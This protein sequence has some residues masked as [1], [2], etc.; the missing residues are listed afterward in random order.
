MLYL[1]TE[2]TISSLVTEPTHSIIHQS[3]NSKEGEEPLNGD[4]FGLAWYAPHLPEEPALFKAVTPAWNNM[5]LLSLARVTKSSCIL[6]HVR[7]ATPGLPVIQLNCHPF[8]RGSISFMHNGKVGGFA[9]IRR[10]IIERL[11][12]AAFESIEGSTDSEYVFALFLDQY[13][14]QDQGLAKSERLARALGATIKEVNSIVDEAGIEDASFLN[15]AVAD[16]TSAVVCRY[17]SCGSKRANT[18][19][20]HTGSS[21]SCVDG[22]YTMAEPDKG[23]HAVVVASEPLGSNSEW[24][25]V[26]ESSMVV[27]ESG[28]GVVM[29]PIQAPPA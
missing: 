12:D 3:Y 7:A 5:N 10:R 9:K 20:I 21:F 29:R 15:L 11:S 6:A 16:G 27:I 23:T 14:A 25:V 17:V 2:I 8:V 22:L 28:T 13:S 19:Y 4:G 18:L 26:P 1:G 24:T